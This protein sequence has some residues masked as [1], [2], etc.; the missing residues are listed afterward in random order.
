MCSDD[1]NATCSAPAVAFA[2]AI[3]WSVPD[4]AA[5]TLDPR[6]FAVLVTAQVQSNPAQIALHWPIA[7]AATGYAISRKLLGD[8][9]WTTQAL[10]PANAS[11]YTDST[12][13]A[14]AGYEYEIAQSAFDGINA[15]GYIYAG[16]E[17]PI[18]GDRGRTILIVDNAFASD[19]SNELNVFA[20]DLVGDGWTVLRHDVSR[21]AA[22]ADVRNLVQSDYNAD[23]VNTR[24][25]ILIGHVPVPYSGDI[26]PD[27]HPSHRGA[28]PADVF[29]GELNSVWT[30]NSVDDT[31]AEDPRNHNVPGD[32]KFDQSNI[33]GQALLQVGRID[34]ADLPAFGPRSEVDLLRQYFQKNH[35]F[36][37]KAFDPVRRGIIRDN[38][39]V[40]DGDAPATD[41]WRSFTAF[42]GSAI[43]TVD[44]GQFFPT[45]SSA[46]YL[47][48]YAG[49]GG[50]YYQADGVGSTTDFANNSPQAVFFMLDGS[51]FGDWDSPDNFLRAALASSGYGLAAAW[52][53]LPHWFLHPMALGETIGFSTLLAQNNHDLYKNEVNLGIGEVHI[54]LMGDPTLRMHVVAPPPTLTAS[55][56]GSDTV[57][58]NWAA[59]PDATLGYY[60]YRADSAAGPFSRL[61]RRFLSTTSFIDTAVPAGAKVYMVRAIKLENSASGSYYNAS[62]GAFASVNDVSGAVNHPPSISALGNVTVAESSPVAPIAFTIGD[63]ETPASALS[64][65]ATASN[66]GLLPPSS[67]VLTGSDSNRTLVL[68]PVSG[69][70]GTSTITISVSD[71]Q[72]VTAATFQLT[73]LGPGSVDSLTRVATGATSILLDGTPGQVYRVFSSTNLIDWINAGQGNLDTSGKSKFMDSTPASE[74]C[75][76]YRVQW[77]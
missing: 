5:A 10:L 74:I 15:Y 2:A 20:L 73:V 44:T 33:P 40:I 38:F 7:S 53:G 60:L 37:N 68:T 48:A 9:A 43:D 11:G 25:V 32:G 42:F 1:L 8:S 47:W 56:S 69:Q 23:P 57:S 28:W 39:G 3:L 41:A 54:S 72:N 71:G 36:R 22:P 55:A 50:E 62:Q 70:T 16:I 77:P 65:S 75:R 35:N 52:T 59:S 58:L 17:L 76:F 30:D 64:V 6:D 34:F 19:L 46:S 21:T 4:L 12:V 49:G 14:G 51:W 24:A 45:L 61:T 63:V 29:Y 13:V 27:L 31:S 66:N 67:I 18:A 26:N